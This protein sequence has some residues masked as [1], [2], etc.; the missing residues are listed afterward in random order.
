M[1]DWIY[2]FKMEGNLSVSNPFIK[3]EDV[4]ESDNK[5]ENTQR[6]EVIIH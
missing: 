5:N 3:L 1:V 2:N 6:K 4:D